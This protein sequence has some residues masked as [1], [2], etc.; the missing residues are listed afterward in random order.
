M[1]TNRIKL[2]IPIIIFA[3]LAAFLYPAIWSEPNKLPDVTI[4]KHIPE[5]QLATLDS[6]LKEN[7]DHNALL[8]SPFIMNVWA[9]WC[10]VCVVE[11]PFLYSLYESGIKIVGINYKD[12]SDLARAWLEKHKNPY[13]VTLFDERGRLGF[14]LGV[15]GAPETFLVAADGQILYR[16]IGELNASVWQ[17]HFSAAFY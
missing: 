9:T 1:S 5:F 7:I 2:F 3:T 13:A 6:E 10:A 14:D 16:H 8:G 11:H 15:T 4:G 17:E 12:E